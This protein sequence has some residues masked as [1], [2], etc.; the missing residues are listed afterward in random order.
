L[1]RRKTWFLRSFLRVIFLFL[2]FISF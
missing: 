2:S 1:L